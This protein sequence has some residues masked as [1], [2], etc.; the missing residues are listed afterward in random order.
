LPC[1]P[2]TRSGDRLEAGRTPR[3][4]TRLSAVGVT[5]LKDDDW[6]AADAA[7]ALLAY[8]ISIAE[9]GPT[10][11]TKHEYQAAHK[12]VFADPTA[13]RVAD[14]KLI[15]FKNPDLLWSHPC[16]VATGSGSWALRRGASHELI[17]PVIEALIDTSESPTDHLI[18]G[19]TVRLN[20]DSV[21]DGW[22]KAIARRDNDPD[23]AITMARTLLE[24]TLKTVLEDRGVAYKDS[25]DLPTLYKAVSRELALAPGAYSEQSFKQ[26]LGGCN[27]VVLGLGSLRNKAGDA[28]GSGRKSYRPAVRHATL[29]VNLAGSMALFL[30]ET[31]EAR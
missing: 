21:R 2:I 26:I 24:S 19:A 16:S 23:G 4:G 29:A 31:H 27:S 30:I 12:R 28:H 10:T 7:E 20:A 18:T 25:D 8:A 1:E 14:K 9:N 17:D 6:T 15:R 22:D 11:V 3:R 13:R 5:S